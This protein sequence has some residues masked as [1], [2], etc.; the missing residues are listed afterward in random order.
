MRIKLK[1]GIVM[2]MALSLCMPLHT[3]AAQGG[4]TESFQ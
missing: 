4:Y 1:E 3:A 2:A